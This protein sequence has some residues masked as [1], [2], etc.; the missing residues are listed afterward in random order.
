LDQDLQAASG[1]VFSPGCSTNLSAPARL[2]PRREVISCNT[3][4]FVPLGLLRASSLPVFPSGILT[5]AVLAAEGASS[6][7]VGSAALWLR[8]EVIGVA[9]ADV[10]IEPGEGSMRRLRDALA[11]IATGPVPSAGWLSGGSVVPAMTAYGKV[12]C[13]LERGRQDW[14]RLR[15]GAG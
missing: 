9:D 6:L 13:L 7:L 2:G 14:A 10:I 4:F 1:S 3:W 8:G 11:G 12:D 15:R 5:A